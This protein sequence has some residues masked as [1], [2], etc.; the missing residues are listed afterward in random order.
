MSPPVHDERANDVQHWVGRTNAEQEERD[1][2]ENR[3]E[4]SSWHGGQSGR[5]GKEA[6]L[7]GMHVSQALNHQPEYEVYL[8]SSKTRS[9]TWINPQKPYNG[10]NTKR[11][12]D[13]KSSI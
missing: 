5:E 4:L 6:D 7:P 11:G 2:E 1:E 13:L 3:P 8:E 10:E 12:D 9:V